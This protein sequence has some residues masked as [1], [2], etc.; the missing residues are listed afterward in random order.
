MSCVILG[1]DWKYRDECNRKSKNPK[2]TR[3]FIAQHDIILDD[4]DVDT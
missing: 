3:K 4:F 1:A 2:Y